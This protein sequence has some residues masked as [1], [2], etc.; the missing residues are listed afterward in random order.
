MDALEA[1]PP[2]VLVGHSWGAELIG[3]F[4]AHRPEEVSGLVFLDPTPRFSSEFMLAAG[5]GPEALAARVDSLR[6]VALSAEAEGV[7]A[8]DAVLEYVLTGTAPGD[9]PVIPD[10]PV[11]IAVLI[12]ARPT[13]ESEAF[14]A[15]KIEYFS[16]AVQGRSN[17]TLVIDTNMGHDVYQA[18]STLTIELVRRVVRDAIGASGR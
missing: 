9:I 6:A 12:A 15:L 7:A 8:E 14:T 18:D 16:E 11:P 1:S 2:Y 10:L 13:P 4:A 17:A 5:F 3:R